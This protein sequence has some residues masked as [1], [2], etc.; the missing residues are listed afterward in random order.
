MN[1]N[2]NINVGKFESAMMKSI[3][4][5]LNYMCKVSR[6]D[7]LA[8]NAIKFPLM[9]YIERNLSIEKGQ[10]EC[11]YKDILSIDC[12]NTDRYVDIMWEDKNTEYLIELKYVKND[13]KAKK[14]LYFNDLVRLS[15]ALRLK[16]NK[17]RRCFFLVCGKTTEFIEQFQ[18]QLPQDDYKGGNSIKQ[19]RGRKPVQPFS[20]WLLF[21]NKGNEV[22]KE[23]YYDS[24]V[25]TGPFVNFI[26]EYFKGNADSS[27]YNKRRIKKINKEDCI[28]Y[29][30]SFY[31]RQIWQMSSINDEQATG[32]WE[33]VL[34][35]EQD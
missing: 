6:I 35:K 14:Q 33:V 30:C 31:T 3:H 7:L 22:Y 21:N 13:T 11:N 9:E 34:K 4:H 19:K 27:S 23:I 18:G 25:K 5:W 26:K 8:E 15:L 12:F 28:Q 24:I 29:L 17:N 32:L 16:K 10:I 2:R 1:T 20:K